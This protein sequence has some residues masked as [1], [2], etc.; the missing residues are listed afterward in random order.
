MSDVSLMKIGSCVYN[1]SKKS[2]YFMLLQSSV[3]TRFKVRVQ[4]RCP[5]IFEN[6]VDL[7]DF[8]L[9]LIIFFGFYFILFIILN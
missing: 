1:L 7:M 8:K 9:I 3:R 2:F 4:G 5:N 6:K